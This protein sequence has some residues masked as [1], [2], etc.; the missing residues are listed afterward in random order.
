MNDAM[1]MMVIMQVLYQFHEPVFASIY[2]VQVLTH[3]ADIVDA[4]SYNVP[5]ALLNVLPKKR[6]SL[7]GEFD[8]VT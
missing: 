4:S 8:A 2:L 3:S 6:D 1:M 5:Q 7:V